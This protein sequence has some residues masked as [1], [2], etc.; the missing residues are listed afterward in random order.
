MNKIIIVFVAVFYT[1]DLSAYVQILK[2]KELFIGNTTDI[3]FLVIF[4]V[5]GGWYFCCLLPEIDVF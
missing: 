1:Y 4:F 2:T 3:S 5:G